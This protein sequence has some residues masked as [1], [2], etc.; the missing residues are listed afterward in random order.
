MGN[1]CLREEGEI[2]TGRGGPRDAL[3]GG[4]PVPERVVTKGVAML[5]LVQAC[6]RSRGF[7][8][9]RAD[10]RAEEMLADTDNCKGRG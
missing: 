5:S 7:A 4:S 2:R 9:A 10:C 1:A 6:L 8:G 3:M